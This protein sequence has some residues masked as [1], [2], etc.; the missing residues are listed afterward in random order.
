M[1]E[2]YAKELLR[3][4]IPQNEG[5]TYI[6][7]EIVA[8]PTY[9]VS[10]G[11]SKRHTTTLE[12]VE[13]IVLRLVSQ[14]I[15]DLDVIARVLGLP[16]DILDITIGD[17]HVKDFAYH[18]S[19]KCVLMDKGRL[20]LKNLSVSKREKDTISNVYVDAVN[21]E[22]YS[23]RNSDY[24]ES[25]LHNDMKMRHKIDGNSVD[26]YR[27]STSIINSIFEQTNKTFLEGEMKLQ[28]E[29]VSIDSVDFLV[30]GYIM[31]PIHIYVSE[32]SIDIDI[33]AKNKHQRKIIEAHKS[34]IIEQLRARKLLPNLFEKKN[35][36][37]PAPDHIAM[38]SFD[39]QYKLI[40]ALFASDN[41]IT[42]S[43]LRSL[44][45]GARQLFDNELI[46]FCKFM[47]PD[48]KTIEIRIDDLTYWSK[49]SKFISICSY[50]TQKNQCLLCYKSSSGNKNSSMQRIRKSCP[51][52]SQERI[53][54]SEHESFFKLTFD[55]K[56]ELSIYAEPI[57]VFS[58]DTFLIHTLAFITSSEDPNEVSC[59]MPAK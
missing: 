33:V 38:L 26:F 7:T 53:I 37:K 6:T 43:Q 8:I 9:R 45:L 51:N 21:G 28:D 12:L 20:A 44:L 22:I 11:I 58:D 23:E 42:D 55:S 1:I 57:K 40:D 50:I 18:S 13:E 15:E 56:I 31:I 29:L 46:E 34:F 27:K 30:S 16:R 4:R 2:N 41:C 14:N 36:W 32:T 52:I 59:S 54:E 5:Y 49:N 47:I 10:L 24:S 17:L 3:N 48:S 39:E 25:R 19:G 35:I